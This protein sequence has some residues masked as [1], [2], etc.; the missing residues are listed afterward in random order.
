MPQGL[1]PLPFGIDHIRPQYHHGPTELNNLGLA[2]FNCNTFK[3]A[4][5]AGYDP[6]TNT[7]C[8]L[9]NRRVDNWSDHFRWAGPLLDGKTPMGRT[10]IHVLRINIPERVEQRRLLMAT[11]SYA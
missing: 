8:A 7:L 5:A 10:T 11:G 4:N 2:C 1:D 9:Y 6:D 3:G